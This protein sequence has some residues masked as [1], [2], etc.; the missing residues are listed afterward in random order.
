MKYVI[1]QG[2][3]SIDRNAHIGYVVGCAENSDL[4]FEDITTSLELAEKLVRL[5]NQSDLSPI[6]LKDVVEDFLTEYT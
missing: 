5:C 1:I 4:F 6:H 3:Y 2:L